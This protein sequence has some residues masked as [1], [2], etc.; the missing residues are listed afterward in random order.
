MTSRFNEAGPSVHYDDPP[1]EDI[2]GFC[3]A[4]FWSSR[5]SVYLCRFEA[6]GYGNRGCDSIR[7]S[8][9]GYYIGKK[10]FKVSGGHGGIVSKP[11]SNRSRVNKRREKQSLQVICFD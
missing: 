10:V 9:S 6:F 7:S 2:F 3:F 1:G 11:I 8:M 4:C 5:I